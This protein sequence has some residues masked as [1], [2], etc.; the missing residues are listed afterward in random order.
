MPRRE[1]GD[2]AMKTLVLILTVV[3]MVTQSGFAQ[4]KTFVPNFT[5]DVAFLKQHVEVIVLSDK[6]G[7]TQVAVIPAYQCRVMT[8]TAGGPQG[9]SYGW[10]NRDL[11][12]SGEKKEH[13]NVYGGEDRF[14]IGPEGG[15]YSVFFKKGDPFDLDHWSTP[16]SIPPAPTTVS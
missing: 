2:G 12:S 7:S 9:I 10:V 16:A 8:S 1:Q 15:Q 11:I 5:D 3:V 14:W 4:L 6:T 13:I